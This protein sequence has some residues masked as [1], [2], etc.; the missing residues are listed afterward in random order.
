[1]SARVL[2]FVACA[3]ACAVAHI[4]ILISTLRSRTA[5]D[6]PAV[7]RPRAAV[8][9]LWALVPVVVLAL[10]LTATWARV[11]EQPARAAEMMKVAQ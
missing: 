7:P 10:V 2:V 5:V 4:A 9:A 6:A 1:V 8:E 11:R 3:V